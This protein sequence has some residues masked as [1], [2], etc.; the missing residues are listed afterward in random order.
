M[1]PL[2]LHHEETTCQRANRCQ[3]LRAVRHLGRHPYFSAFRRTSAHRLAFLVSCHSQLQPTVHCNHQVLAPHTCHTLPPSTLPHCH[4][5][6]SC[7]CS[8]SHDAFAFN[9]S[10]T[11]DG[12]MRRWLPLH[13]RHLHFNPSF[14]RVFSTNDAIDS[15]DIRCGSSGHVTV[16]YVARASSS[17]PAADVPSIAC[18]ISV[19][20]STMSLL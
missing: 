17:P 15:V 19:I 4:S 12:T 11:P 8:R 5:C 20:Y 7:L 14:R 16:E 2:D 9:S 18:T 10:T 1:D 13:R 6:H 3:E